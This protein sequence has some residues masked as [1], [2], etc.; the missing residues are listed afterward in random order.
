MWIQRLTIR[1]K[2]TDNGIG[3]YPAMGLAEARAAAFE[4]W[5]T[6][7]AGG[8]PREAGSRPPAPTFAEAAEAVIAIHE[9]SWR[10]PK[11]GA[12][13]R[14][15]LKTYAYPSLGAVPVSEITP[16]HV[17]AALEP[18]WNEKRETA[19]RVKQRIS[20]ICRW[21]VAQGHRTDDPAGVVVEA[22]LPRNGVQRRHMPALPYEEVADCIAKVRGSARA[23]ESSQQFPLAGLVV[24]C[25][26]LEPLGWE[27]SDRSGERSPSQ[28]RAVLTSRLPLPLNNLLVAPPVTAPSAITRCH[29]PQA[30][31]DGSRRRWPRRAPP[32]P[33]A[34]SRGT[35][36]A[37]APR[38]S[39]PVRPCD[40]PPGTG[41]ST[42]AGTGR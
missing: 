29:R 40:G 6:T 4:R 11:S 25:G 30:S 5:K 27:C 38:S 42:A 13:W 24:A 9:P 8:D 12:Q 26:G 1:G 34:D 3:H 19:R 41:C 35:A 14:A 31:S 22:A 39:A 2:R 21:A 20:A 33:G 10:N 7:K 18:L 28:C 32:S 16:G 15:S 37:A 17:M 23:S 36:R